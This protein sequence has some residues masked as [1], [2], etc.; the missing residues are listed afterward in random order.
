MLCYSRLPASAAAGQEEKA[1]AV[2]GPGAEKTDGEI[3][4]LL[5]RDRKVSANSSAQFWSSMSLEKDKNETEID[6]VCRSFSH[7]TQVNDHE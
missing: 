5:W 1:K 3:V 4:F 7:K 6:S 2:A